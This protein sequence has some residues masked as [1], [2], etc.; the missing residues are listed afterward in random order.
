MTRNRNE[1]ARASRPW[2]VYP[3]SQTY[4]LGTKALWPRAPPS[5]LTPMAD[6]KRAGRIGSIFWSILIAVGII[7]LAGSIM[8]PST[9]R[10]RIHF[11]Q[12]DQSDPT[13]T[14]TTTTTN[15]ATLP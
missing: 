9:K 2:I 10:A 11:Q 14:A 12:F 6:L 7:A 1:V 15:P 8:M 3:R 5:Y 13:T 4:S